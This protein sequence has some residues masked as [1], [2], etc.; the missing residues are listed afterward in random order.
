MLQ[1]FIA[2][3]EYTVYMWIKLDILTHTSPFS[4]INVINSF[5][6]SFTDARY[7]IGQRMKSYWGP[8]V[9]LGYTYKMVIVTNISFCEMLYCRNKNVQCL[10]HRIG[11]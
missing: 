9:Y 1:L 7:M 3:H 10:S 4:C 6:H 8:E 11:L 2:Q 5:I